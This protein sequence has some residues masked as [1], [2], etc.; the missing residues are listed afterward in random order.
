M[1]ANSPPTINVTLPTDFTFIIGRQTEFIRSEYLFSEPD[2]EPISIEV[3]Y[4]PVA[5]FFNYNDVN[6]TFTS[7]PPAGSEGTYQMTITA[8]DG[9]SD[10]ANTSQT[11]SD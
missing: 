8:S 10:T 3:S 5:A 2:G 4:S 6:R 1:N 9:N 11:V 7:T